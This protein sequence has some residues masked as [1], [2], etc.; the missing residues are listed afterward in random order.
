MEISQSLEDT[1]FRYISQKYT[2]ENYT[3][4]KYTFGSKEIAYAVFPTRP[5]KDGVPVFRRGARL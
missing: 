1:Q 2:L 3:L 5:S 4:E